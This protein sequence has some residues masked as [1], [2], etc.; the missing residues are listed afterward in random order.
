MK[1]IIVRHAETAENAKIQDIGHDDG[2]LLTKQGILQAQKLG[3]TLRYEKI[4]HAY[5][6]P[7]KRAVHT[8]QEILAH[9]PKVKITHEASLKEQNLGIYEKAPKHVWKEV[10]VKSKEPFHLFKPPQGESYSELQKRVVEFFNELIDKHENETVFI[11][12]HRGTLGMLYL[13][14]LDKEIT[15]E[16]YKVYKPENTAV[17]ILEIY[18][19][20]PVIVHKINSLEHLILT[21]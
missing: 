14:L 8:A 6:S 10:K 12:S 19:N 17:T 5:V 1:V 16:N 11:V 20:K 9:H 4:S 13:H 3:D 18:K 2:A 21:Y 7:Q 15:E